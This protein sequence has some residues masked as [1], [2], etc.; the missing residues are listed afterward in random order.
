MKRLIGL[1]AV[2]ILA[3]ALALFA[4]NGNPAP[5]RGQGSAPHAYCDKDGDG[6][7][8]LT[9]LPVGQCRDAGCPGCGQNCP[10]NGQGQ[11]QGQGRGQGPRDGSCP[12]AGAAGQGPAAARR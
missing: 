10:R 9:G 4:Q 12:R 8:D 1:I 5:G 3:A 7:C 11:G 2:G 6:F